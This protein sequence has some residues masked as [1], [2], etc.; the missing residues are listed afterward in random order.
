LKQSKGLE[1]DFV[2]DISDASSKDDLRKSMTFL[3]PGVKLVAEE[4]DA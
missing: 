3:I 1:S 2:F 4:R